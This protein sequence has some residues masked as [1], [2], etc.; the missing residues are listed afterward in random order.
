MTNFIQLLLASACVAVC[1]HGTADAL[2]VTTATI[3]YFGMKAY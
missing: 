2:R 1:N 3:G